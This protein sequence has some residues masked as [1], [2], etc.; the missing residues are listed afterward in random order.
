MKEQKEKGKKRKNYVPPKIEAYEAAPSALLA[1]SPY[2]DHQQGFDGG[3]GF[4][5]HLR[6]FS[7]VWDP[8]PK[9]E[10][11]FSGIHKR[12]IDGELGGGVHLRGNAADW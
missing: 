8:I 6:G 2:Y 3:D 12:G 1:G 5:D 10:P 7:G 11:G 9:E 4:G